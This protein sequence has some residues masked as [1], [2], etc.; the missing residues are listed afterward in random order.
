MRWCTKGTIAATDGQVESWMKADACKR[1]HDEKTGPSPPLSHRV[2][3]LAEG[4]RLGWTEPERSSRARF[5]GPSSVSH[6]L[7][8]PAAPQDFNRQSPNKG[9]DFGPRVGKATAASVCG[10]IGKNTQRKE[11]EAA[12][13]DRV[14]LVLKS[15]GGATGSAVQR[16][17][18]W[19]S[20]R[21]AAERFWGW[22]AGRL[23]TEA[24]WTE[25]QLRQRC[26]G[27]AN[28]LNRWKSVIV[29]NRR[30][31]VPGMPSVYLASMEH[32]SEF[33]REVP[34]LHPS[35]RRSVAVAVFGQHPAVMGSIRRTS[36]SASR[37]GSA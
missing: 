14:A 15:R 23:E 34:H 31:R 11:A 24:F 25:F 17:L 22:P 21:K 2:D 27:S 18:P 26:S 28:F 3:E 6:A 12:S 37:C 36:A 13:E 19:E 8:R 20:T 33:P 30:G 32:G 5:R 16:R 10:E 35:K 29:A 7:C 9:S 1:L 4:G